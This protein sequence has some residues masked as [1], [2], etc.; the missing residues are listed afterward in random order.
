MSKRRRNDKLAIIPAAILCF[1]VVYILTNHGNH[2]ASE[3]EIPPQSPVVESP[4][5]T[6]LRIANGLQGMG[7]LIVA[8]E[9]VRIPNV[10][11]QV[12]G[13]LLNRRYHSAKHLIEGAV[14]AGIDTSRISSNNVTY[15]AQHRNFLVILPPAIV[16]SCRVTDIEQ[17]DHSFTLLAVD[18]GELRRLAHQQAL[19][20]LAQQAI[21]DG[22]LHRAET[23][24]AELVNLVINSL[25]G[26]QAR[27]VFEARSAEIELP[28]SC[29]AEPPD[30]WQ[31]D[32]PEAWIN[33][34]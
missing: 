13:G 12:N 15:D 4:L 21:D 11:V 14:S 25:T 24:A 28:A 5:V 17:Y 20:Q 31:R 19:E 1:L 10:R 9:S 8:T 3:T 2:S 26:Y 33:N 7:N 30:G 18:W 16:A 27:V 23:E 34:D 22:I 32:G 6:T 29:L